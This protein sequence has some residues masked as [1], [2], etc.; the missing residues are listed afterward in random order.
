MSIQVS[1]KK[2]LMRLSFYRSMARFATLLIPIL[3][4]EMLPILL[5]LI[6]SRICINQILLDLKHRPIIAFF[7]TGRYDTITNQLKIMRISNF[8]IDSTCYTMIITK[9]QIFILTSFAIFVSHPS[10]GSNITRLPLF[11]LLL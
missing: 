1:E 2:L 6:K 4:F 8:R 9:I 7:N 5:I 11:L 3:G 10:I